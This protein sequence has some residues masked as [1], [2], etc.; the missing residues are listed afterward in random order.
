VLD[1]TTYYFSAFALDTN[2]N[3]LDTQT[4]S[5]TTDFWWHVSANTLLYLKLEEDVTDRSLTPKSI[6]SSSISYTTVGWVKS[7][8]VWSSWWISVTTSQFISASE[9]KATCSFLY[10]VSST[11]IN[12]RRV[13]FEFRNPTSSFSALID[14][15]QSNIIWW[16]VRQWLSAQNEWWKW[17]HIVITWDVNWIN[18]YKDGVLQSSIAWS[19]TP[20][21]SW[22]LTDYNVQNIMKSRDNT[23]WLQW[24]MREL[25]M[26]NKVRSSDDV[27]KYSI[28]IRKKLWII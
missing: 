1:E 21:R 19:S 16:Y 11:T 18:L 26:E 8:H 6:S 24:N 4:L 27:A 9:S 22:T 20:R 14:A 12:T 25:I 13:M 28:W 23:Y 3:I 17:I 5:I 15:N 2:G 10:Y 7:A